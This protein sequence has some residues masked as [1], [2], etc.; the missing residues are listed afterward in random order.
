MTQISSCSVLVSAAAPWAVPCAPSAR[1]RNFTFLPTAAAGWW[2]APSRQ[3]LAPHHSTTLSK[4]ATSQPTTTEEPLPVRCFIS[5][6]QVSLL[7]PSRP[8]T[9]VSADLL[10]TNFCQPFHVCGLSRFLSTLWPCFPSVW[11]PA[12]DKEWVDAQ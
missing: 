5:L 6:S 11:R 8:L 1:L 2:W 4:G 12:K 9:V 7:G 10:K 3:T